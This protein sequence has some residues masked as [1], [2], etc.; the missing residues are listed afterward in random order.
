MPI[1]SAMV[2][3][4]TSTEFHSA[5]ITPEND[6]KKLIEPRS[7]LGTPVLGKAVTSLGDDRVFTS[8]R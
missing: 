2:S 4:A 3:T 5:L 8:S 6:R 1:E 7:K